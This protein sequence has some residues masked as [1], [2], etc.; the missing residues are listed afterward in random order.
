MAPLP[1]TY[2]DPKLAKLP[3]MV[4]S[5]VAFVIIFGTL[6]IISCILCV[7]YWYYVKCKNWDA[8]H[9]KLSKQWRNVKLWFCCQ[10][11]RHPKH[12]ENDCH[13]FTG[14]DRL[15][16]RPNWSLANPSGNAP[17]E[18]ENREALRR[19]GLVV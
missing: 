13:L 17:G 5:G 15:S 8:F 3:W 4:S 7:S 9:K 1:P 14:P 6:A 12:P 19:A 16:G 2:Q 10:Y 18:N 11:V